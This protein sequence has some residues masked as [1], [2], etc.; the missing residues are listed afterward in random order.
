[1]SFHLNRTD[2]LA[3]HS[4]QLSMLTEQPC[5]VSVLAANTGIGRMSDSAPKLATLDLSEFLEEYP[6]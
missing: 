3:I 4:V 1:M 2:I 5:A 6:A